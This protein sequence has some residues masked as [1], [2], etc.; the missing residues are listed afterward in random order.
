MRQFLHTL[1]G[2]RVAYEPYQ[3]VAD[4]FPDIPRERFAK[5][6]HLWLH[7]GSLPDGEMLAGAHAVFRA[8]AFAPGRAWLLL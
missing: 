6:V 1:T 2:G 8:L 7:D 5:A 4:Q 3:K